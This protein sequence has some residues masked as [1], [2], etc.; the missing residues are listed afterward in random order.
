M[1]GHY[2]IAVV[3]IEVTIEQWVGIATH[4][5]A[6]DPITFVYPLYALLRW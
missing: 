1:L 3:T 2:R 6:S 4:V 5:M